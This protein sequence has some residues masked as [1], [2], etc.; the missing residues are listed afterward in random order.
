MGDAAIEVTT[1]KPL[2]VRLQAPRFAVEGDEVT[3]SANVHND[4]AAGKDVTA[5]L[6]IPAALFE[7]TGK[8]EGL[9]GPDKEGNL[10]L[11]ASATVGS[12]GQHRFDW[13]LK[14]RSEGVAKITV[15]ARCDETGDAMRLELPIHQRGSLETQSQSGAAAAEDLSE[16]SL[17]FNLPT[18]VDPAKT[19]IELSL[20]PSACV[21]AFD[22]LPF[23]AGYPYGCVEQTMSRF[24]PTV[25]AADTLRKLGLDIRSPRQGRANA[26]RRG[27]DGLRPSRSS[28]PPNWNG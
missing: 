23:L 15:M 26:S 22:A 4:L 5:E 7:S 3:L 13:P 21:G 8:S 11:T 19:R 16:K 9:T 17:S 24:Y 20:A 25:L 6:T 27:L 18:E 10:H 28:I 2:L 12:H 1:F 14:A